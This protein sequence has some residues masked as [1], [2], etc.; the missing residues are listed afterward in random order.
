MKEN[1]KPLIASVKRK[2]LSEEVIDQVI[3]LLID[4]TLKPGDKLPS[5]IELAEMLS[6]SRPVLREAMS[7]LG[8]LGVIDRKT[9]GGTYFAQKISSRPFSIMLALSAGNIVEIVE[10]RMALELGLV[11]LAAEDITDDELEKLKLTITEMANDRE[12]YSKYDREFHRI[13]ALSGSRTIFEGMVDAILT[14]FDR[15]ISELKEKEHSVTLEHH[16]K[17]YQALKERSPIE[18][19]RHMYTHM[20]FVRKRILANHKK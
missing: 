12:D 2:T 7:S 8:S 4:G 6:V 16:K 19:F 10:S 20:D 17:I 3:Q 11:A 18:A 15:T 1:E 9:R 13:I 5:E 14:A